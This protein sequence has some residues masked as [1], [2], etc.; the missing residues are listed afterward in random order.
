MANKVLTIRQQEDW[1]SRIRARACEL[2]KKRGGKHG[3]EIEDWIAA[4]EEICGNEK[5]AA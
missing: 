4:E 2:C 5:K 1:E 3:L